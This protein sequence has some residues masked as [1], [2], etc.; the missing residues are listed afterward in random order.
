MGNLGASYFG[1]DQEAAQWAQI[2]GIASKMND[3][4]EKEH[5]SSA[6]ETLKNGGSLPD[7]TRDSIKVNAT[8]LLRDNLEGETVAAEQQIMADIASKAK[9][10]GV[11]IHDYLKGNVES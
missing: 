4:F 6:Y 8:K 1:K 9:E 5:I 2:A 3:K 10:Q 7:D 11:G